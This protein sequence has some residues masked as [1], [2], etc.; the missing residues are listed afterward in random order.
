MPSRTFPPP[1]PHKRHSVSGSDSGSVGRR[2]ALASCVSVS[3][4]QYS[5]CGRAHTREWLARSIT[6]F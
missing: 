4:S 1:P 3:V 5:K 6:C 2:N